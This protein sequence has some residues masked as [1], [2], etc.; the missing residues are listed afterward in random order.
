MATSHTH[1]SDRR[2]FWEVQVVYDPDDGGAE[3]AYTIGLHTRGLPELHLWARPSLGDD[4]GADWMLSMR[5][6]CHVLNDLGQLLVDGRLRI[7]TELTREYDGGLTRVRYRVDPPGSRDELQA[8]GVPDGVDVLPVRWSL[9]RPEEGVATPISAEAAESAGALW[10]GITAQLPGRGRPPRGW[11][12]PD[13]PCFGHDQHFG[14]LTAVVLARAAQ[15]WQADDATLTRL[16]RAAVDVQ[17]GSGLGHVWSIAAALARPHGRGPGLAELRR[18]VGGLV[19][20]LTLAPAA[21]RRWRSIVR[22]V[23][24]VWWEELD[25]A[26]RHQVERNLA[27]M[28][29]DVTLGCLAVEAVADVAQPALLLEGR[30]PWL[31]GLSG[32]RLP[33]APEWEASA[34]VVATVT[35]LLRPL[36]VQ[37]LCLVGYVHRLAMTGDA[38]G[39]EEYPDLCTRLLSWATVSA[40]VFPEQVL[41]E[42]PGWAPLVSGVPGATVTSPPELHEW[43][44]CLAAAL[45]HRGRLS[46]DEVRL[47]TRLAGSL[48]PGLTSALNRPV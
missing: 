5:D 34:E 36:D 25:R 14:P 48:L 27:G 13:E 44:T 35:D 19:E 4:P 11:E 16:L 7:G 20:G 9:H 18:R 3:F 40:A 1:E 15:L 2:P 38:E 47:L 33:T 31:R 37:R 32:D 26:G 46:A 24:P 23:D 21:G 42:L 30:G 45:T 28:L 22:A 43:A 17:C 29:H 41:D 39:L 6:R 12:L 10:H 8:L